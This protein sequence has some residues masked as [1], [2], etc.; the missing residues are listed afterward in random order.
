MEVSRTI[1]EVF[2]AVTKSQKGIERQSDLLK[3]KLLALVEIQ[4]LLTAPA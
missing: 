4:K 1:D 2:C 3:C